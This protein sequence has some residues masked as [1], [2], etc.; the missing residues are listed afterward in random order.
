ML[1]FSNLRLRILRSNKKIY[2]RTAKYKKLQMSVRRYSWNWSRLASTTT[3]KMSI[4]ASQRRISESRSSA[5]RSRML[6]A[7]QRNSNRHITWCKTCVIV[8]PL[9]RSVL[10]V[11]LVQLRRS[12]RMS[13]IGSTSGSKN[14]IWTCRRCRRSYV[15][16]SSNYRMLKL[17]ERC[18]F[19]QWSRSGASRAPF[20]G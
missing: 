4:E 14:L 17:N 12:L 2:N 5:R 6:R 20:P 13:Q 19:S 16:A 18:E 1:A 15:W 8:V 10:N 7:W 11:A 9:N 3:T